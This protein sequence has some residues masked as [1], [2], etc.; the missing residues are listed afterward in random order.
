[1]WADRSRRTVK[2]GVG[3]KIPTH[4]LKVFSLHIRT[5]V[6]KTKSF[7]N[8][9]MQLLL[10]KHA[11]KLSRGVCLVSSKLCYVRK[12]ADSVWHLLKIKQLFG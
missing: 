2:N 7:E 10:N 8:Q 5:L 3:T 9:T 11:E 12:R 1:M 6:P 4:R